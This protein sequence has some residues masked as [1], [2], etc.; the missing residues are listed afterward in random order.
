M[1]IMQAIARA[2]SVLG[3]QIWKPLHEYAQGL[4]NLS[5]AEIGRES[6]TASVIGEEMACV[7]VVVAV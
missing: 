4:W 6:Q 7:I 1:E 5:R 3:G 2:Y